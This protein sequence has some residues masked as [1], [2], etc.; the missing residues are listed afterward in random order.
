M[1]KLKD[2]QNGERKSTFYVSDGSQASLFDLLSI[3]EPAYTPLTGKV[4]KI[5]FSP[6]ER[7]RVGHFQLQI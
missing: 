6:E 1:S 7:H 5:Y 2:L 3:D 4:S